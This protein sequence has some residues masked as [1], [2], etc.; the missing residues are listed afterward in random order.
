MRPLIPFAAMLVLI[1]G[2]AT[3]EII[4]DWKRRT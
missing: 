4:A 3:Y 1:T 2:W